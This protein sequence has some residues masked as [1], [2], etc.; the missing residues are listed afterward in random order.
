MLGCGRATFGLHAVGARREMKGS[1]LVGPLS[2]AVL[3]FLPLRLAGQ[4]GNLRVVVVTSGSSVDTDGYIVALDTLRQSVGMNGSVVFTKV[5]PGINTAILLDVPEDCIV[6]EGNP[7]KIVVRRDGVAELR[8]DVV[9]G[10]SVPESPAPPAPAEPPAAPIEPVEPPAPLEPA[11]P[12]AP[13]EPV[14][15][16][17]APLEPAELPAA[18]LEPVEPPAQ[19]PAEP[20][21]APLEPVEPPARRDEPQE[22]RLPTPGASP[23]G[24]FAAGLWVGTLEPPGFSSY[25]VL[26]TFYAEQELGE[27]V[28]DAEYESPSPCS[29]D[30]LLEFVGTGELV[31]VQQLLRGDCANGTRVILRREGEKLL[32]HWLK[33]DKSAWFEAELSRIST[34][35]F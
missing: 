31:V 6:P 17:A 16:P 29:Y 2:L 26:I 19:A 28:G 25:P 10:E 9:C 24:D 11:Q 33:P 21:A 22:N 30:L 8:F 4:T 34:I 1:S 27:V 7:R 15:P 5:K 23:M 14:E 13:L 32:A 18:P 3:L 12:P 20:P 35:R